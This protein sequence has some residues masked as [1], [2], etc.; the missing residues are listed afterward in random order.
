MPGYA[1]LHEQVECPTDGCPE[2]AES[3]SACTVCAARIP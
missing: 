1:V 2:W 3:G